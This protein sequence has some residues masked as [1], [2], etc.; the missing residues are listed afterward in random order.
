MKENPMREIGIEK[1][2]INICIGESGEKLERAKKLL[3]SLTGKNAVKTKTKK[4]STFG[5]QK[6]R[7]IGVKVT[8]RKK[9]AADFLKKI[10]DS[11]ERKLN[12]KCFDGN[13]NFS[14]GIH[15]HIDI[16]GIRYDP[17]IGIFGMDVCV[18]LGRPGFRI[19][20][21]KISKSVGKSHRISKEESMDFV[22]KKFEIEVI[23]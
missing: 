8:L 20:R 7:P 22:K 3:E 14:I 4:R 6:G 17:K 12:I 11:K 2:T 1:V 21:R 19:K 13:G 10:I 18:T 16:P 15:E 5:V 9:N 23:K